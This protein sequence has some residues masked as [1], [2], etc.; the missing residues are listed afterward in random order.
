M[1][2]VASSPSTVNIGPRFWAFTSVRTSSADIEL[3]IARDGVIASRA[4]PELHGAIYHRVRRGELVPLLPGVYTTPAAAADPRARLAAVPWWDPD[5]VLTHE[6]AAALTFWPSLKVPVVRCAVR[7][8]KAPQPG[9]LFAREQIPPELIQQRET[10]R[11]TSPALTA[12][13]LAAA[14]DGNSV[15]R[16][17]F[18]RATTLDLMHEAL[19]LTGRRRGNP[20]RRRLLLDSREEPWSSAERQCHRLLREA[21]IIGWKANRPVTIDGQD[22]FVDI[23]FR[24]LR[25]VVEIDGR[26][27]HIGAE[28]FESDR[29]RQNLLVLHGWRVL[30]ITWAMITDE[31]DRVLEL[32]REAMIQSAAA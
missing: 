23:L 8:R 9:Y 14:T 4:H 10:L 24:R 27:F 32:V 26:E 31:P 15:D 5:A 2:F 7:H 12:L 16:A 22:Y 18:E 6:A 17:L 13:D 19:R 30:R 28:V 3:A 1:Q 21:G 20:D 11:L 29:E 25:L